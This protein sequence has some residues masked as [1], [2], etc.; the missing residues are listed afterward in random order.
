MNRKILADGHEKAIEGI[1][2]GETKAML[3]YKII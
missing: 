1:L 2:K 3:E